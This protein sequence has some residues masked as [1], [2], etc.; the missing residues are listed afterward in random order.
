MEVYHEVKETRKWGSAS[1]EY[2]HGHGQVSVYLNMDSITR[3][4]CSQ[5]AEYVLGS[6]INLR[7]GCSLPSCRPR[8][9]CFIYSWLHCDLIFNWLQW[10]RSVYHQFPD[11]TTFKTSTLSDSHTVILSW[12]MRC[13]GSL[14]LPRYARIP[15]PKAERERFVCERDSW[16]RKR[17]VKRVWLGNNQ[18]NSQPSNHPEPVASF[19]KTQNSGLEAEAMLMGQSGRSSTVAFVHEDDNEPSGARFSYSWCDASEAAIP[20]Q[21]GRREMT[22]RRPFCPPIDVWI[23]YL[24]PLDSTAGSFQAHR[25]LTASNL[26]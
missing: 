1:Q 14:A 20:N 23:A 11:L 2:L 22:A 9:R 10:S 18:R 8:R 26:F 7:I 13:K 24:L 25:L 6:M 17:F 16:V 19:F 21:E 5:L 4:H 3:T 12:S 15:G